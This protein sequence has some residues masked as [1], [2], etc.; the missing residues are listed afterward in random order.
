MLAMLMC[1]LVAAAADE[2]EPARNA[3]PPVILN[4]AIK[5]DDLVSRFTATSLV[6]VSVI[7]EVERNGRVEKITATEL[8][9]VIRTIENKLDLRK[10]TITTAGGKKL[11]LEDARK[12]LEKPQPIVL[13][14]DGKAVDA[15]FLKLLDKDALVIVAPMPV[16]QFGKPDPVPL[17][18]PPKKD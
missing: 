4:A 9:A 13:S 17:P 15:A 10:A 6:P 11:T 7:K 12:R 8:R 2:A 18:P 16:Q 14:S 3:P 1:A 5:G